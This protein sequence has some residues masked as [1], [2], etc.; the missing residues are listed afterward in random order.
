MILNFLVGAGLVKRVP[1]RLM[2]GPSRSV[3]AT[4]TPEQAPS[5]Y[6]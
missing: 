1:K 5:T 6:G 2:L 3:D 4:N